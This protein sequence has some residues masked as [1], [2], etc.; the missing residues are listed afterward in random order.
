MRWVQIAILSTALEACVAAD[1]P[2]AGQL[3]VLGTDRFQ[4]TELSSVVRPLYDEQA[5]HGRQV[6]LDRRLRKA[7]LCPEGYQII[8]RVPPMAYGA[9]NKRVNEH[10]V[11]PVTYTGEC[12][13]AGSIDEAADRITRRR[14]GNQ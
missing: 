7:H 12:D 2:S 14:H 8:E 5:E 9:F 13:I 10:V 11:T 3:E 4:Y 6:R 1:R